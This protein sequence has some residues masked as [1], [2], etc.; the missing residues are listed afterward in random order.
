MSSIEDYKKYTSIVNLSGGVDSTFLLL[1]YLSEQKNVV[2]HHCNMI[3]GEGRYL[4][5]KSATS[6]V[7]TWLKDNGLSTFE[8]YESGFDYGNLPYILKDIE[9]IAVFTSAILRAPSF[10]HIEEIAVSANATDE[11]N[12]PHDISV[13][14]RQSI[15]NTL[16]PPF[17]EAKLTFPIIHIS[18]EDMVRSLPVDLLQL[19][20]FCRKPTYYNA[21]NEKVHYRDEDSAVYAETCKRCIPCVKIFPVLEELSITYDK[22]YL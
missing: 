17:V 18:K 2:V 14:N 10:H 11:S 20:W 13:I 12:N 15:L 1:K 6:K 9:V 21:D 16:K 7:I 19:T 8:Y 4:A 5:E 3:N 22:Y